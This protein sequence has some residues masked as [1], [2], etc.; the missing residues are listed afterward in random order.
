MRG[1]VIAVLLQV[2]IT[3][4]F[5]ARADFWLHRHT[6]GNGGDVIYCKHP[7][8]PPQVEL[9]DLYEART[10]RG[11]HADWGK[12]NRNV[13]SK[14]R[15]AI[16]H[17][18]PL[19]NGM[20]AQ[21]WK[22]AQNFMDEALFLPDVVLRDVP[23][24]GHV[25][26]P[27]HCQIR[28]IAIQIEPQYPEDHRYIVDQD[29]W[30]RLGND[31][32]AGLILHEVLYRLALQW[33][34]KN[35]ITA[36]YFNSYLFSGKISDFNPQEFF[37]YLRMIRIPVVNIGGVELDL[38]ALDTCFGSYH[39]NQPNHDQFIFGP[40]GDLLKYTNQYYCPKVVRL[41]QGEVTMLDHSLTLT[42]YP[43]G[44][45][46]TLPA[47]GD[48]MIQGRARLVQTR[49]FYENGMIRGLYLYRY[50]RLQKED[51]STACF[52]GTVRMNPQ[53]LVIRGQE[54]KPNFCLG[55]PTQP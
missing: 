27:A 16:Q 13:M 2:G 53:G 25:A 33:D 38:F 52:S 44:Q 46:K 15:H 45:L 23:D 1:I 29:L 21:L 48:L 37:D 28:Q 7:E 35:S 6:V 4:S 55:L 22:W 19:A 47:K 5:N 14:V 32:K 43:G 8:S 41:K 26:I 30:D 34:H 39:W 3:A 40:S 17:L 9:L 11:I 36:R 49:D 10:I 24:S 50:E 31:S 54:Y 20:K 42:F 51:L 18:E 12:G